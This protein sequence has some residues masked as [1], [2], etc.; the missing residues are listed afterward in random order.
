M[1]ANYWNVLPGELVE[2]PLFCVIE[3]SG[4]TF[5]II[6]VKPIT[7]Y[8]K[9]VM[10]LKLLSPMG[11][12]FSHAH[13][14]NF[15]YT[16]LM[17]FQSQHLMKKLKLVWEKQQRSLITS[18]TRSGNLPGWFSHLR[19]IH[20]LPLTG[21]IENVYKYQKFRSH[22]YLSDNYL[23]PNFRILELS[24][25]VTKPSYTKGRHTSSY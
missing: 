15:S 16:Q 25:R 5:L 7:A 22:I 2:R 24:N 9:R 6:K 18:T 10:G 4:Y 21:S 11:N 17:L 8:S 23:L 14:I 19:D 13:P 20:G 1:K 12:H 3:K